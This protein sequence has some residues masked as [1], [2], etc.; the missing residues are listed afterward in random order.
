MTFR[1]SIYICK[2][3]LKEFLVTGKHTRCVLEFE[4]FKIQIKKKILMKLVKSSY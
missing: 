4:I 2:L 1:I 3:I